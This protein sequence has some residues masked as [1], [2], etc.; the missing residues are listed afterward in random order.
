[1][2]LLLIKIQNIERCSIKVVVLNLQCRCDVDCLRRSVG[3]GCAYQRI[4]TRFMETSQ[5]LSC[6]TRVKP[7]LSLG[8]VNFYVV[9]RAN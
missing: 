2:Q 9:T 6:L 1:M 3:A 4:V 8:T 7:N 5:T